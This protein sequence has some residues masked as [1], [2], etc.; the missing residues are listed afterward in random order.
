MA[1]ATRVDL[2]AQGW[3]LLGTSLKPKG[4]EF[5]DASPTAPIASVLV[6]TDALSVKGSGPGWLYTLDEALQGRVGVRVRLGDVA[7]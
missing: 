4:F 3:C 5:R 1:G 7:W 2:P 6:K